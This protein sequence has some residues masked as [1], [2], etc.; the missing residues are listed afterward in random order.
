MSSHSSTSSLVVLTA[1]LLAAQTRAAVPPVPS[2]RSVGLASTLR[3]SATGDAALSLNPSGMSILRTYAVEAAYLLDQ[4]GS[5]S[6]HNAHL[7]IVDS[8]SALNIAGGVYY[9]YLND[10]VRSGHEGGAA[11]SFPLGE[12]FFLGA[13]AR[14]LRLRTDNPVPPGFPALV[15]GF[16]FDAGLTI[17][18]SPLL[19]IGL[20]A[21]NLA[22]AGLGDRAPRTFAGGLAVG[23]TSELLL[24]ADAVYD[25]TDSAHTW[26]R[27]A[28]G[29]E[30]LIAKWI[31]VRAGGGR[32]GDTGA[33][34]VSVG[35][36]F[37]SDVAALDAGVQ[38]DLSGAKE[39]LV[40]VSGRIFVAAP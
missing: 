14:Y 6:A 19:G 26:W 40:G 5:A 32:R 29:A 23:A 38:K 39:L 31:A 35:L 18:P 1:S 11:L 25:L 20:V 24:A 4:V 3:G 8:T 36:S 30:L 27:L 33:G 34:L 10:A 28:G 37:I 22:D 9:T 21:T 16:A 17:K 2:T 7:S 13:T 12:H 15:S